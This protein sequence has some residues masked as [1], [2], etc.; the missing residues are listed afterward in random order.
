MPKEFVIQ[1][2][3]VRNWRE[4]MSVPLQM[5]ST[6]PLLSVSMPTEPWAGKAPAVTGTPLTIAEAG[7]GTRSAAA[8]ASGRSRRRI[9]GGW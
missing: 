7:D 5:A 6:K 4:P 8:A 3:A 9:N 1:R 2:A